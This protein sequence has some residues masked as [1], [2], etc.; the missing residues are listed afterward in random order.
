[1]IADVLYLAYLMR[2]TQSGNYINCRESR[3]PTRRD[4]EVIKS[5]NK[6]HRGAFILA[7]GM[8]SHSVHPDHYQIKASLNVN[9]GG[10]SGSAISAYK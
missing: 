6:L 10:K 8:S 2:D 4:N 7:N 3:L 5:R 1:M 9:E